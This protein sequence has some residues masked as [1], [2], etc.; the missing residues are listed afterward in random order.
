[1][2]LHS[3]KWR[4]FVKDNIV[5]VTM[6]EARKPKPTYVDT[7]R[8]HKELLEDSGLVAKYIK[9]KRMMEEQQ[10]AQEEHDRHV[11]DRMREGAMKQLSGEEH[12]AILEPTHTCFLVVLSHILTVLSYEAEIMAV[13]VI[14]NTVIMS[15]WAWGDKNTT[16]VIF[17][18]IS[19]SEE[20]DQPHPIPGLPHSKEGR[21]KR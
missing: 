16:I 6:M 10:R 8:G 9:K 1:M 5:K 14:L 19:S 21:T 17:I 2:G 3:K 13:L 20:I 11:S 7:N 12:A 15:L 18:I 4:N